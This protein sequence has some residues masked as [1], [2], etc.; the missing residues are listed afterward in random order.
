VSE[1]VTAEYAEVSAD[2]S[3]HHLSDEHARAMGLPK[4][5]LHGLC[6]YGFV[7]QAALEQHGVPEERVRRVRG[8]FREIVLPGDT[9]EIETWPTDGQSLG[10][11][12]RTGRGTVAEECVI[13]LADPGS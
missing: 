9:I 7:A 2:D 6:T 8:R 5:I 13:D 1:S 4:R 11:V 12:A 10:A 3:L